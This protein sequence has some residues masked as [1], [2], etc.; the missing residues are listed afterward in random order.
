MFSFDRYLFS[1]VLFV[2]LSRLCYGDVREKVDVKIIN[3]F[4]NGIDLNVHC[5]SKDDDLA[6]HVLAPLIN[7]LNSISN[8]TFG[9]PPY[10][11]VDSGGKV[12]PIGLTYSIR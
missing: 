1:F 10:F 11:F 7:S 3:G 6:A 5:E 12:N 2:F 8:Q 9:V 4:P